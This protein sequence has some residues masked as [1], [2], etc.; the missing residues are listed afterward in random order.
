M[1]AT[2]ALAARI[3]RQIADIV[4]ERG[5]GAVDESY[6]EIAWKWLLDIER[7]Y[8]E[9][10]ALPHLRR[11]RRAIEESLN[12]RSSDDPSVDSSEVTSDLAGLQTSEIGAFGGGA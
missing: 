5:V 1:T 3:A 12:L 9:D 8:P 10:K 11:A 4:N 2:A 7:R 6:R